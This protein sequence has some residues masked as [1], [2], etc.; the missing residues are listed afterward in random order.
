MIIQIGGEQF[1][2]GTLTGDT[3]AICSR[4]YNSTTIAAHN[5][6]DAAADGGL[7]AVRQFITIKGGSMTTY[8]HFTE[9]SFRACRVLSDSSY[10]TA[11]L[12][13]QN[14]FVPS[15]GPVVQ[16]L[17]Y[18]P[19][20][21]GLDDIVALK[22]YGN[23]TMSRWADVRDA[24]YSLAQ[25]ATESDA[26]GYRFPAQ[27]FQNGLVGKSL[28]ED[29]QLSGDPRAP[30]MIK[31]LAD[32]I[33]EFYDQTNHWWQNIEGPCPTSPWGGDANYWFTATD[34]TGNCGNY[35]TPTNQGWQRYQMHAVSIMWWYYAY[36]GDTTYRDRG[37]ELFQHN[38]DF[39]QGAGIGG[40][41]GKDNSEIYHNSFNGVGWRSGAL[42]VNQ[43]FGDATSTPAP[44]ISGSSRKY[45]ASR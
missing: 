6:G 44:R 39:T 41:S 24:V 2:C 34:V 7:P 27:A 42:S 28:I 18:R 35:S 40:L 45:G 23:V 22:K 15:F 38:F 29:W 5:N 36:T 8:G 26:S 14:N 32:I 33:W 9:S 3:Y 11:G 37:D 12:L 20:T 13:M 21:Y 17:A 30:W 43:W 4:G 1:G 19:D 25:Q 16:P 31:R 10:C